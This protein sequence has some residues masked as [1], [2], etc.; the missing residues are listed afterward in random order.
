MTVNQ[1]AMEKRLFSRSLF[2]VFFGHP[3][4]LWP[5]GVLSEAL[6]CL[7]GNAVINA[8]L[9]VFKPVNILIIDNYRRTYL[10]L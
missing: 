8:S 1:N 9:C 6:W 7:F 4:F 2:H 5:C 3:L 10:V